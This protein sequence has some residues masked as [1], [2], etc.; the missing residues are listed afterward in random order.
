MRPKNILP[1]AVGIGIKPSAHSAPMIVWAAIEYALAEKRRASPSSTSGQHHEVHRGCFSRTG[2]TS[3]PTTAFRARSSPAANPGSRQQGTPT[4]L[5][6][7]ANAKMIE[8][9][10]D[11]MTADQR[12]KIV[13][14]V[15]TVLAAIW[16]THGG[17]KWKS[18][19]HA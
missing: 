17:G 13:K 12:A 7:E 8:P 2:A 6:A 9:G 3:S 10:Y 1:V 15:E 19:E 18:K 11:M 5:T 14:E 16:S 4:P